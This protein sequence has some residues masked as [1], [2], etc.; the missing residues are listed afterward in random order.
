MSESLDVLSPAAPPPGLSTAEAARQ[1][2][3]AVTGSRRELVSAEGAR[4]EFLEIL[5]DLGPVFTGFARFLSTRPDVAPGGLR[6]DF[7]R[8]ADR[9]APAPYAEIRQLLEAVWHGPIEQVCFS[10]EEIPTEMRFPTQSHRAWLSPTE[11][12]IVTCVPRAFEAR[13]ECDLQMLPML[14]TALAPTLGGPDA[15]RRVV[16]DYRRRVRSLLDL[17]A[18]VTASGALVADAQRFPA[19]RGRRA[20]PGLSSAHIAV[21]DDIAAVPPDS[22]AFDPA[23]AGASACLAWLRQALLGSAFPEDTTASDFMIAGRRE[24]AL[25]GRCFTSLPRDGQLNIQGYLV[26]TA[27]GDPDLV[28]HYLRRE[29]VAGRDVDAVAFLRRIRHAWSVD[30]DAAGGSELMAQLLLHWRIAVEH[31]YQPTARLVSFYRGCL[32]AVA[33]STAMGA[34]ADVLR[35][36]LASLQIRMLASQVEAFTGVSRSTIRSAREVEWR[37]LNALASLPIQLWTAADQTSGGAITVVAALLFT[38]ATIGFA[39]PP[40]VAS[41]AHWADR[42]GALLFG[43]VGGLTLL[44]ILLRSDRR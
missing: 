6:A 9:I 24:V 15:F 11:A 25:A 4:G 17:S 10:I 40:V 37:F 21:W 2:L 38:L 22:P 1:R 31:G 39:V 16:D 14:S 32:A 30:T 28:A 23:D 7:S 33:A 19:L 29:L 41:G 36:A 5:G 27:A 42:F 12:V 35:H 26:A 13:L 34:E 43:G 3:E 20:H 18:D 44:G 8:V